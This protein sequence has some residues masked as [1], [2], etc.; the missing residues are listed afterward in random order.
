MKTTR[1]RKKKSGKLLA[2]IE[3]GANVRGI[4]NWFTLA[5]GFLYGELDDRLD[6]RSALR[7]ILKKPVP[8]HINFWFCFGGFTFLLFVV[9]NI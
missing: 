7:K 3:K 8:K 4:I 1:S 5:T 2:K 9:N 6:L